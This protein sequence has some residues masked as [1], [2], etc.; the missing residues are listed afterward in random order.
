[1]IPGLLALADLQGRSLSI[2]G[3]TFSA[4][5]VSSSK[6]L[7]TAVGEFYGSGLVDFADLFGSR[8]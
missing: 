6:G 8:R 7:D 3:T 4:E 2:G 1:M 5:E